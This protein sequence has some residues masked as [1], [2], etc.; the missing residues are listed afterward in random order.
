M[1][2]K[3]PKFRYHEILQWSDIGRSTPKMP[4]QKEPEICSS[5]ISP[6]IVLW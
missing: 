2:Q 6:M 3:E 1:H 4:H 5:Q